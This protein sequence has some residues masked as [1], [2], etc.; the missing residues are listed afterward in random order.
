MKK[1][2]RSYKTS[3]YDMKGGT[4]KTGDIIRLTPSDFQRIA[5]H[6]SILQVLN[7]FSTDSKYSENLWAVLNKPCDMVHNSN[8]KFKHNLFLCPLQGLLSAIK[9]GPLDDCLHSTISKTPAAAL[10]DAFADYSR[11][12][13]REK[14]PKPVDKTP[15]EHGRELEGLVKNA[16]GKVAELVGQLATEEDDPEGIL[17]D[18][19]KA[20]RKNQL[21]YQDLRNFGESKEFKKVVD[22]HKSN[23]QKQKAVIISPAK[24]DKLA[25]LCLNQFDTQ[26]VFF[27][28][29]HQKIWKASH[30]LAHII[31]LEEMMT[32]KVKLELR[33]SGELVQLLLDR[34]VISLTENFSDR[35]QNIMGNYYSKIGTDDVS[36]SPIM[37][38]YHR[39][40]SKKFFWTP[41]DY[42]KRSQPKT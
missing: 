23:I 32:L 24:H 35:L 30:D 37:E 33:E 17:S 41:G 3:M 21:A 39:I 15:V 31:R 16:I 27:Y 36:S 19:K 20:V 12:N 40:L 42:E 38:L 25:S 14:Y 6:Q 9:F 7:Q 11:R 2:I 4:L 29:P 22:A 8:Q 5:R 18:L 1:S 28:E 34:R 10:K 13:T 26:G